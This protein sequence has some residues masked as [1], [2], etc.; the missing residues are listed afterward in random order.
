M[1]V[2]EWRE[3]V[4]W[5]VRSGV[6]WNGMK[7]LLETVGGGYWQRNTNLYLVSSFGAAKPAGRRGVSIVVVIVVQ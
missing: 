5:S 2:C 4:Q 3:L 7:W 6:E 1:I